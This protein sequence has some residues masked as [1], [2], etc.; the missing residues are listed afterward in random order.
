MSRLLAAATILLLFSNAWAH[1]GQVTRTLFLEAAGEQLQILVELKVGGLE[2]RRSLLV[3]ADLD[4]D[5]RLSEPERKRLEL[6]LSARALDGLR[7]QTATASVAIQ[8][9]QAK[10]RLEP[11]G[12]SV[13]LVL[14]TARLAGDRWQLSTTPSAEPVTLRVVPGSRGVIETSRGQ[15]SP[16]GFNARLGP[17]DRVIWRFG[18][19]I[20]GVSK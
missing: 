5:G 8:D 2:R 16:G 13:L 4:R 11:E 15:L 1:Q 6:Q 18:P 12:P 17:G 7:L 14:G 20:P 19:S 9:V 3:L 10:L